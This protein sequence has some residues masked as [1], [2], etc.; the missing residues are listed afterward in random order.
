MKA[1]LRNIGRFLAYSNLWVGMNVMALTMLTFL[2]TGTVMIPYLI[3]SFLGTFVIYNYARAF[4]PSEDSLTVANPIRSWMVHHSTGLLVMTF[5]AVPVILWIVLGFSF[6]SWGWLV[7]AA[8]ISLAYPLPIQPQKRG[9]V[10]YQQGIKIFAIAFVWVIVTYI[11]PLIESGITPDLD[12]ALGATERFLFIIGITIPFDIRD[13]KD[14]DR[15]LST[16]PMILG[17]GGARFLAIACLV[18][19]MILLSLRQWYFGAWPLG[20]FYAQ[21]V[22]LFFAIILVRGS[23]DQRDDLYFSFLLEGTS[24]IWFLAAFIFF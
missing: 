11:L 12:H 13:M 20:S 17:V 9:G 10:R 15:E 19:A 5:L 16:L 8:V 4:E 23:N 2:Q 6:S 24:L 18:G 7:A 14:D 1:F 22:A 3:F 21:V